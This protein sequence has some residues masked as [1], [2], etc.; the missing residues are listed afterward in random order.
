MVFRSEG[1]V[2]VLFEEAPFLAL[3]GLG[4]LFVVAPGDKLVWQ[5]I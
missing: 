1:V 2:L 5:V 3:L 4:T